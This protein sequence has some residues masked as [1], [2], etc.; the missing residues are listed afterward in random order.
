MWSCLF[1]FGKKRFCKSVKG[2]AIQGGGDHGDPQTQ[3]IWRIWKFP[4][5]WRSSKHRIFQKM[6]NIH[7]LWNLVI[8]AAAYKGYKNSYIEG[9]LESIYIPFY[10]IKII[11]IPENQPVND[12]EQD[13]SRR[14]KHSWDTVLWYH[15][16]FMIIAIIIET[17]PII[18]S[19]SW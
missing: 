19:L 1:Y 14:E 16:I 11:W 10:P 6:G 13:K 17:G 5:I 18:T 8:C 7:Y 9:Y 15:I 2:E 4:I 12:V 3:D